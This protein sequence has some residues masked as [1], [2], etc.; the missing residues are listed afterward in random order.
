MMPRTDGAMHHSHGHAVDAAHR[1]EAR[2][3]L[4]I[5]F[6]PAHQRFFVQ[7]HRRIA[8]DRAHMLRLE[9]DHPPHS[10]SFTLTTGR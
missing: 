10:F 1:A 8:I 2:H 4:A 7:Q 6:R 9:R 5:Q 3:R